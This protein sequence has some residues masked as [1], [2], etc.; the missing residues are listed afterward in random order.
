MSDG[1][2]WSAGVVEIKLGTWRDALVKAE[3]NIT[4]AAVAARISRSYATVL[5]KKFDL[6]DFAAE[7]RAKA[8]G[9][10]VRGGERKGVV[11]GRPK[12]KDSSK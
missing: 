8:G 5:M 11:T 6:V 4:V 3:G 10:K 7:L 9:V 2:A 1:T 12:I